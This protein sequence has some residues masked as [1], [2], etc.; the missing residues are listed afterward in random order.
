MTTPGP[1]DLLFII[2]AF[3]EEEALPGVLAELAEAYPDADV[4]VIDDGSS[5]TTAAVARTGGAVVLQLPYNLGIGG[6]L[7]TGFRYAVRKGYQRAVQFD[8]DG[9]HHPDEV[10]A[11]LAGLDA[12]ADMVVGSRFFDGRPPGYRVGRLRKAAMA[13]LT[14]TM[15][16]IAGKD[17]SDTSS[18]FRAFARPVLEFFAETYPADYMESVEALF[19]TVRAGY[20]VVEVP[21]TMRNRELGAPSN[22]TWRLVYHYLRLFVVLLAAA[23]RSRRPG[24]PADT[25]APEASP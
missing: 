12:G 8:A 22:R 16:R 9:Q 4:V 6:A 20:D 23:P 14:V 24:P 3:N 17:F 13:V 19:S 21:V 11:L 25:P 5:D 1:A 2:P 7:R 10:P 15:R 18:G